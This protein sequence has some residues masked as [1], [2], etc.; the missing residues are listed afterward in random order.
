[1]TTP[2]RTLNGPYKAVVSD[3]KDPKKQNR[4]KVTMQFFNT[5]KAT[6]K[7]SS[8]DWIEPVVQPGLVLSAP[9]IGQGVWVMFKSGDPAHPVWIGEFGTHKDK[10]KKILVKPLPDT[11]S[12]TGITDQII[13]VTNPDKTKTIDLMATILAMAN[14]IKDHETRIAALESNLTSLHSTLASR[15][16][17]SH[18]HTSAG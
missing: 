1:M 6:Q 7:L 12:L 5:P 2:I 15:T 13:V 14:K 18:T 8:T 3:N 4:I 9:A 17:P 11:T 16:S 10:T